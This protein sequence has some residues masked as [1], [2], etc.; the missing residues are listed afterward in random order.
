MIRD[1]S[2]RTRTVADMVLW[3]AERD[4]EPPRTVPLER[5]PQNGVYRGRCAVRVL[6]PGVCTEKFERFLFGDSTSESRE[7]G[8]RNRWKNQGRAVR[9]RAPSR[10]RQTDSPS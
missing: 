5:P 4:A 2:N 3:D 8:R 7:R 1:A 9:V 6:P 10:M